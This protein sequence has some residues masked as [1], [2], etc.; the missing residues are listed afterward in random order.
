MADGSLPAASFPE[1]YERYLVASIFK[2][3]V[4]DL[5]DSAGLTPTDNLLDVACGTGI[6]ARTARARLQRRAR[7][8]G[9]DVNR[10]MLA[11]AR[12][13]APDI[14]WR[15][16]NAMALPLAPGETFDV[17]LCQQGLQFMPD[18]A[19]A[20][21]E[22]RR[23]LGPGGRAA[24]AVWRP[25]EDVPFFA[26]LHE[27]AERHL[28]PFVDRRHA[29]GDAGALADLLREGGL[30]DVRVRT[31]SRICELDEPSMFI[32][33]NTTAVI[34]MSGASERLTPEARHAAAEQ[35]VADSAAVLAAFT[36]G[37]RVRFELRSNVAV[38][39]AL[40]G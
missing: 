25:H 34:G 7:V 14:D 24:V 9:V 18:R 22:I 33:L 31:V 13:I 19:A 23:A 40:A 2:P 4:D 26:A 37:G 16:G 3:W 15:E 17:V 8:V 10:E 6:V 27:V 36:G 29:Y 39:R 11:V 32:Q 20:A 35:V 12:G 21:R 38:G 5:L 28:G 30:Q 1:L